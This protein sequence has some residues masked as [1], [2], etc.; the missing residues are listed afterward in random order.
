MNE[1]LKKMK[2]AKV[3]E[4]L[5]L[6]GDEGM[7]KADACKKAGISAWTL[8]KCLNEDPD[9]AAPLVQQRSAMLREDYEKVQEVHRGLLHKL[10]ARAAEANLSQGDVLSLELRLAQIEDRL[11]L[12]LG[13]KG[14][15]TPESSR[16]AEEYLK[17][18]TGPTLRP[19]TAVITQRER[20]TTVEITA[21]QPQEV[22]EGKVREIT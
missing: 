2:R 11:A 12:Q 6:V 21:D 5:R 15:P 4:A 1:Q 16:I 18:L 10:L 14:G 3:L 20:V 13:E 22:I 19:G 7:T 9:I 17:K 8:S